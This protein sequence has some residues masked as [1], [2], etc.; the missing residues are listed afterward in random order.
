[1]NTFYIGICRG[2][3]ITNHSL[4]ASMISMSTLSTAYPIVILTHVVNIEINE[5]GT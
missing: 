4:A 2:L 3:F 1:L 5:T